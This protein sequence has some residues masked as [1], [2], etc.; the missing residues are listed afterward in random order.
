LSCSESR[1]APRSDTLL[2]LSRMMPTVLSISCVL[3]QR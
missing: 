2:M 3:R 1:R